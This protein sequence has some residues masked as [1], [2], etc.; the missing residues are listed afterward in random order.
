MKQQ[1]PFQS[2]SKLTLDHGKE[3]EVI[4]SCNG[5]GPTTRVLIG[6][7]V[8]GGL[9]LVGLVLF[10]LALA[11]PLRGS[12]SLNAYIWSLAVLIVPVGIGIVFGLQCFQLG[13]DRNV[14]TI[15]RDRI[16]V[17]TEGKLGRHDYSF[18]LSKIGAIRVQT[19]PF[20]GISTG[21]FGTCLF[22]RHD[23][24]DCLLVS[25][26]IA[27]LEWVESLVLERMRTADERSFEN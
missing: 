7:F 2:T 9:T 8:W 23:Y 18:P 10:L 27:E 15:S 20:S 21:F 25:A 22:V 14:V 5:E 19:N 6:L 12:V 1:S 17:S 4:I 11:A 16:R 3:D 24:K 26:T 13:W